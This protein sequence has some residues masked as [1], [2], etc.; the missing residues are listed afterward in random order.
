MW[1]TNK[2]PGTEMQAASTPAVDFLVM[3]AEA[4][5]SRQWMQP[6]VEN[7]ADQIP[8]PEAFGHV[9]VADSS[10]DGKGLFVSRPVQAGALVAPMRIAGMRTPAGR[11][12]NHSMAP[13]AKA[14]LLP[15][16]DMDL[17][18]LRDLAGGEEV[19]LEYRQVGALQG[20]V[21]EAV[22]GLEHV[23]TRLAMPNQVVPRL[24]AGLPAHAVSFVAGDMAGKREAA[25]ADA[26]AQGAK[27]EPGSTRARLFQL[28]EA[29]GE[30]PEVDCPLQHVFAPGAY[31]RTIFIPKG[32]VIVGKI[33][34]HA[35]LNIL[36]QG[37]VTVQTEGGG[38]ERL[39]GPLTIVSPPGTKR[40]V[41]AHTDTTWTTIHLTDE[42][43]LDKIEEHVIA[44]TYEDYE[45]F[46]LE[47]DTK[48]LEVQS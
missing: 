14:V 15:S 43:D 5:L 11:Y 28:Q 40:A 34:K 19:T 33:H 42:T 6:I 31:A 27:A 44:K 20:H 8:M 16:G 3:M 46:L 23:R 25:I 32:T 1:P 13:N 17:V 29:V 26:A 30:L 21:F 41:Y 36:S 45:Q 35:H 9:R 47:A 4:G 18:A 38:L 10:I 48:Q 12:T 24:N 39:Q 2:S 7:T 22:R 37:D